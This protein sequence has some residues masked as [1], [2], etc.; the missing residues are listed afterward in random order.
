M[1]WPPPLP[2]LPVLHPNE[3]LYSWAGV[4]HAWNSNPD[5][6][7]TS[8][9]LYG[10]PY[11]ALLH[12]FPSRLNALDER[13]EHCLGSPRHL[14]LC[15][16]LLGYYLPIQDKP[17]ASDILASVCTGSLSQLKYKLG[18]TASRIGGHHPLKGC[19][20]CFDEDE[21]NHGRAYWHLQ[22]QFPSAMA[23]VEHRCNLR[24]AWDPITPVHRRGW[25]LPRMGLARKWIEIPEMDST[26][27]ERLVRLA[28]FSS[29]WASLEPG[30]L[31]PYVLA[32]TYQLALRA[33]G[34]ATSAGNL[35]LKNLVA[36][37]CS[38]Y[39]GFEDLPGFEVLRSIR[40]EWPGLAASL[41]RRIPKRR[42]HPLKHLLLITMLFESWPEFINLYG[43]QT[44]AF[45]RDPEPRHDVEVSED[46]R[47]EHFK[48]LVTKQDLSITAAAKQVGVTS[49][50]GVRWAKILEIAFTPR[51]KTLTEAKLARIRN[52]LKVG[53]AKEE[54]QRRGDITAVSLNRLLSSEP[55]AANQWHLAR[56]EKLLLE[57]R[58]RYLEVVRSHPGWPVKQIRTIP[59]S[60]YMW[61][62]RH[63]REWLIEHLPSIWL[64]QGLGPSG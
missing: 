1:S 29:S 15:H 54:I 28:A 43:A 25:I 34:L 2:N 49:S 56:H 37:F 5:V 31:D 50:T 7:D 20:R 21:T 40:K 12:D 64:S 13:L 35:R 6:R 27:N 55:D 3:T 16:T 22:H 33:R 52:L 63:D 61:L 47:I 32:A 36:E 26:Q 10:A 58:T 59:G 11:A 45:A 4:V 14:A 57:N 60:G 9:Q 41:A 8:R 46:D 18:I 23:C 30:A 17:V 51:T 44:E 53:L 38:Y 24:I 48:M 62:Y 42:G 39:A 19:F